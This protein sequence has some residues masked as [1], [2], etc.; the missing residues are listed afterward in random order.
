MLKVV[1]RLSLAVILLAIGP[2]VGDLCTNT[3]LL[4]PDVEEWT[5][6]DVSNDRTV[7][8]GMHR[9]RTIAPWSLSR[10]QFAT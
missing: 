1:S 4:P 6:Q 7:V 3:A 10:G 5:A 2:T 8:G 9:G